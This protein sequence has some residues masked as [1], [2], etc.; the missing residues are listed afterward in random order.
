M[1]LCT[2]IQRDKKY[3]STLE[4]TIAKRV[5]EG[6]KFFWA[7]SKKPS[8]E[9]GFTMVGCEFCHACLNLRHAYFG[10]EGTYNHDVSNRLNFDI[11]NFWFSHE[12]QKELGGLLPGEN[13][14]MCTAELAEPGCRFDSTDEYQC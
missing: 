3:E 6:A 2:K 13:K 9:S 12:K 4:K 5:D 14:A 1:W 10:C 8:S 11:T 7:K